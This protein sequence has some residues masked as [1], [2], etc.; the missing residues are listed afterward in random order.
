MALKKV[1]NRVY[2]QSLPYAGNLRIIRRNV[3][4]MIGNEVSVLVTI[5][6]NHFNYILKNA[7][8]RPSRFM[9]NLSTQALR[10][11]LK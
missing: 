2:A 11:K 3:L 10:Q 5:E 4:H 9:K 7:K 1:R 8:S 6:T